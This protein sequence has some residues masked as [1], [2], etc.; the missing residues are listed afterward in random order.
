M[1]NLKFAKSIPLAITDGSD[2]SIDLQVNNPR[3]KNAFINNKNEIQLLPTV[4]IVQLLNNSRATLKSTFNNRQILVTN[5]TVYYIENGILNTV[6]EIIFTLN[7]VRIAENRDNQ[8]TIVNGVGAWVFDQNANT[9]TKL[10][11]SNGFDLTSP[12]DVTTLNTFTIIVGKKDK[13]FIVSDANN[14]LSYNANEVIENDNKLGELTAC[15]VL[16]NNLMIFGEGGVQRWVPSIQRTAFDFPFTQDPSY[17]DE[18]GCQATGSVLSANNQLFYLTKNGQI[19][20]I[21]PNGSLIIAGNDLHDGIAN[22]INDYTDKN[23]SQG[24]YYYHK[25]HYL[26]HLTFPITGEAWVYCAASK[27]WSES[28]LLLLGVSGQPL[29]KDGIYN[30]STDYS[31]NYFEIMIQTPYMK[32]SGNDLMNRASGSLIIMQI[33][34]GKGISSASQICDLQLSKDN[35]Q[36]SNRVRRY[37]SP[38]AERLRQFRWFPNYS[39]T[40]MTCRFIFQLKQDVV[41]EKATFIPYQGEM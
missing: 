41:I 29:L 10:T 5:N 16:N 12:V 14:A 38:T 40:E 27:K 25:G 24:N 7:V 33:T 37:L 4:E 34:Q 22:I 19:R 32:L 8:V 3:L 30:F 13:E 11:I 15:A 21:T 31:A 35:I 26:Y 28:S 6:G 18:Y 39:H 1:V 17:R 23:L 9:F 20:M 2:P 36:F